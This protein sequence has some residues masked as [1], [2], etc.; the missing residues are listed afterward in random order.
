MA[1]AD[2]NR[3]WAHMFD[4]FTNT[5]GL[6]NLLWNMDWYHGGR[7]SGGD[8]SHL[9]VGSQYVDIV[10]VDSTSL[11]IRPEEYANILAFGK[12]IGVGQDGADSAD[13][14]YVDNVYP[15]ITNI[16]ANLPRITHHIQFEKDG[17]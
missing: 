3:I 13:P 6:N 12:P 4:Y 8:V 17:W 7:W 15:Q 9:Y 16:R 10:S 14:T 5:W 1:Q 2:Y 11:D